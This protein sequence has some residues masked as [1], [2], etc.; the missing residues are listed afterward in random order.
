MRIVA[1]PPAKA[2]TKA[3]KIDIFPLNIRNM[4]EKAQLHVN[5]SN[6]QVKPTKRN[7]LFLLN[8]TIF[9]F[10]ISKYMCTYRKRDE[11]YLLFKQRGAF[12]PRFQ[13]EREHETENKQNLDKRIC[14]IYLLF[15]QRGCILT[16]FSRREEA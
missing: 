14:M 8:G 6:V 5:S 9:S 3:S 11:F 10:F 16:T 13:E 12:L 7:P 2:T 1:I 15:E 4:K